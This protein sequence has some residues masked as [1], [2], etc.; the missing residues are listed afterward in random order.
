MKKLFL[1]TL[2]TGMLFNLSA[3]A[4][5]DKSKRASPPAKVSKTLAMGTEISVD[6]SQPSLKG[7]ALSTLAPAGKIWRTGANEASIF[8]VS[9]DVKIEGKSL[10][11]GKYSL[12]TI[13]GDQEWTIIFNKDWKQWGTIY[14]ETEDALRVTVKATKSMETKET[15]VIDIADNG[16]VALNWENTKVIFKVQ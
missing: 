16:N 12:Y 13:P 8:E 14:K 10:A 15:F 11:A 2:I 3:F 1:L 7:R 4:Q 5:Q 6:Y 9:K